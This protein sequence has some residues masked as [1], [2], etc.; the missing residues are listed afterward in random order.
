M[1]PA[2]ISNHRL[3]RSIDYI[4][5]HVHAACCIGLRISYFDLGHSVI[6]PI[7]LARLGTDIKLPY[8]TCHCSRLLPVWTRYL[9]Q[10]TGNLK[11]TCVSYDL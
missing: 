11:Q 5:Q 6:R 2:A 3:L 7:S 10:A 9:L 4:L 8:L 1:T